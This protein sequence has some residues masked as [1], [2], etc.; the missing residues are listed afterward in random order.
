MAEQIEKKAKPIH[1]HGKN[2]AYFR[3]SRRWSQDEFAEKIG[4]SQNQVS[5]YE[6]ME[7]I[8][9]KTLN[10]I[11]KALEIH[12]NYLKE[13]DHDELAKKVINFINNDAEDVTINAHNTGENNID[14][15]ETKIDTQINNPLDKVAELYERIIQL[16]ER[17]KDLEHENK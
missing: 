4:I 1:H 2:I 10:D 8:D 11:A 13:C 16:T 14:H 9:D 5:K 17:I 6:R 3:R 7:T 12:V 15:I